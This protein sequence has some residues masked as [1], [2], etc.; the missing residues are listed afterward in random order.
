[1][2]AWILVSKLMISDHGKSIPQRPREDNVILVHGLKVSPGRHCIQGVSLFRGQDTR[3]ETGDRIE[4]FRSCRS[5][6]APN[7]QG[8]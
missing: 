5:S 4:E 3:Q 6:G 8:A 7:G 1:M 2:S